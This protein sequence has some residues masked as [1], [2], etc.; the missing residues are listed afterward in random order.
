MPFKQQLT[1]KKLIIKANK[2]SRRLVLAG[3]CA[4]SMHMMSCSERPN[5]K[6][7]HLE[8]Y[9]TAPKLNYCEHLQYKNAYWGCPEYT[10][11]LPNGKGFYL[12]PALFRWDKSS[13][14]YEFVF[15]LHVD[16]K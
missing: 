1:V 12:R 11:A 13:E 14:E 6:S 15:F 16:N 3:V 5:Y 8:I 9:T 2:V 4:A 7:H 10:V